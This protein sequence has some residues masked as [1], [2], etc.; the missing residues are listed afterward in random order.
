MK[1][2]ASLSFPAEEPRDRASKPGQPSWTKGNRTRKEVHSFKL[3]PNHST[4]SI[5][6]VAPLRGAED[7]TASYIHG[8]CC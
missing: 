3:T 1:R 8:T 5:L 7:H 2:K 4:P 6:Y